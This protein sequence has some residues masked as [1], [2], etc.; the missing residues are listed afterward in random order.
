MKAVVIREHGGYE[1]LLLEDRP[2]PAPGPGEVLLAVR[3]A[4]L[5]HLDAW[6]RRGVPGHTFPLPIVPG[7]D[8]AG[9]VAAIGAGVAGVRVGARVVALPGRSCGACG[10]CLS[11][12]DNLCRR[13]E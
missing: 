3:A 10:S 12:A 1:K 11:G 5:N 6:V 4:S 8:F 13:Y 9:E 7:S 2:D